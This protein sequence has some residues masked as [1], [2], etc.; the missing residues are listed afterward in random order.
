MKNMIKWYMIYLIIVCGTYAGFLGFNKVHDVHEK[1]KREE[2]RKKKK[3]G[4]I[5][6][7]PRSD[8]TVVDA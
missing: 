1:K 8:Y 6:I 2:E 7:I 5:I 3:Y 4:T